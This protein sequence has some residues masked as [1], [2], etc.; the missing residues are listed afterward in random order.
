VAFDPIFTELTEQ[1]SRGEAHVSVRQYR[2]VHNVGHF[3]YI[4]CGWLDEYGAPSGDI[5]PFA[6]VLF[7]FDP[8]LREREVDLREVPVERKLEKGPLVEERYAVHAGGI[9]ELTIRDVE[10]G[11]EQRH[12]L[13]PS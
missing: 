12:R 13:A 3:R 7:P 11:F 5:T 4:E 10:T 8:A 2:A 9:V 6:E 1:P